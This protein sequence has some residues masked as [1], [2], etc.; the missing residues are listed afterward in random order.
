M[1]QGTSLATAQPNSNDLK[2]SVTVRN[3]L[4]GEQHCAHFGPCCISAVDMTVVESVK[5]AVGLGGS[6]AGEAG[7]KL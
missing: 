7:S 4:V 1:C 2:L 6:G 5:D 3:E